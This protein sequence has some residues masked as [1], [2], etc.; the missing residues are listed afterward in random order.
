M[1]GCSDVYTQLLVDYKDDMRLQG[2][3]AGK[4]YITQHMTAK[5][6]NEYNQFKKA[7]KD[8]KMV[9]Q[10]PG[11]FIPQSMNNFGQMSQP[12]N[13]VSSSNRMGMNNNMFSVY[14]SHNQMQ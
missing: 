2:I 5:D 8:K 13:Y 10:Q 6:R 12:I 7:N 3:F 14:P 4:P 9:L 11:P 1:L